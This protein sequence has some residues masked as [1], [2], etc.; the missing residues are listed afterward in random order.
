MDSSVECR[1]M[2]TGGNCSGRGIGR[3]TFSRLEFVI[4]VIVPA[5][6]FA[7]YSYIAGQDSNWDLMNYHLYIPFR[8]FHKGLGNDFFPAQIQTYLPPFVQIPYYVLYSIL[9]PIPLGMLF[10]AIHGMNASVVYAIARLQFAHHGRQTSVLLA[11]IATVIGASASVFVSEVGTSFPD[12]LVSLLVMLSLLLGLR[13]FVVGSRKSRALL[14]ASGFVM[15]CSTGLRYTDV[16]FLL[17]FVGASCV[18]WPKGGK[19]FYR[20]MAMYAV[21]SIVGFLTTFAPWGA[22]LEARF[23][24]PFFPFLNGVFQSPYAQLANWRDQRWVLHSLEDVV[25]YPVRL[26]LGAANVTTEVYVRDPRYL[27]LTVGIF[28]AIAGAGARGLAFSARSPSAGQIGTGAFK[29]QRGS[30]FLVTY[31]SMSYFLWLALFAYGRYAIP[32]ELLSGVALLL[33]IDFFV[34]GRI[35]K[36]L[37]ALVLCIALLLLGR[38]ASWGRI[39]WG[40][41]ITEIDTTSFSQ[42]ARADAMYVVGAGA[43]PISYVVLGF[44]TS[45]RFIR[46]DGNQLGF[47]SARFDG[48]ICQALSQ[49]KGPIYYLELVRIAAREGYAPVRDTARLARFGVR[50]SDRMAFQFSTRMHGFNVYE[51]SFGDCR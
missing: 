26:A 33:I 11:L 22:L 47:V 34:K 45:A 39:E 37:A 25:L 43:E 49:H 18:F 1:G 50:P 13:G 44:P 40:A 3:S 42:M 6:V 9:P 32:V 15:G 30:L 4:A 38:A 10:G 8:S 28:L 19:R 24:N 20:L 36:I 2:A 51:A 14:L 29:S 21:G 48:E 17:A 31:V 12:I 5:I 16:V 23:G 7:G 35:P 41:P 27:C 46:L